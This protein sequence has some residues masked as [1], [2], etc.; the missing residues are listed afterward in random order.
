MDTG[1][2]IETDGIPYVKSVPLQ[3][4]K[5]GGD[6]GKT[7]HLSTRVENAKFVAMTNAPMHWNFTILTQLQKIKILEI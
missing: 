2:K 1:L 5:T 7:E 4:L 6:K 3:I